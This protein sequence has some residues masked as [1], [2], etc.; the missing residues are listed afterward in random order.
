MRKIILL[1]VAV[2]FSFTTM[3]AQEKNQ[4]LKGAWWGMG[5]LEY[6]STKDVGS[7]FGIMPIVGTFVAPTVTVGLGVGYNST[8]T[9]VDGADDVKA[10]STTVMPL[11][12]KYWGVSDKFFIFGQ[13]AVPFTFAENTSSFGVSLSPGIDYFI[14]GKWTL[15][16]TFGDIGYSSTT[17]NVEGADDIKSNTTNFGINMMTP[18]FGIKYLF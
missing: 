7:S 4:G 2:A 18:K 15:E 17:T 6:S 3:N 11:V 14:G 16:A 12:R 8:V 5:Q 10:N 9:I 1:V 13:A